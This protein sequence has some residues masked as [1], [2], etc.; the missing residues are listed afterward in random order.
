MEPKDKTR[1]YILGVTIFSILI[2]LGMTSI[3]KLTNYL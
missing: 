2:A 3:L 1:A